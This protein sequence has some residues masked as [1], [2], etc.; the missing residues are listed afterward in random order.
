METFLSYGDGE[1]AVKITS[2]NERI[3]FLLEHYKDKNARAKTEEIRDLVDACLILQE[4]CDR[5]LQ[6]ITSEYKKEL[7]THLIKRQI[8]EHLKNT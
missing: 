3:L 8:I 4:D 5:N 1:S 7:N 6:S 2:Q